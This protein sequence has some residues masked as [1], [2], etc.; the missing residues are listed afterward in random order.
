MF[1][2][3]RVISLFAIVSSIFF[4]LGAGFIMHFTLQQPSHWNELPSYTSFTD[5][6]C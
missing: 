5:T 3:M 4:L 2:E 1:T 6:V